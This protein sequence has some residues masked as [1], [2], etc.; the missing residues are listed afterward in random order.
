MSRK[1]KKELEKYGLRNVKNSNSK[2]GKLIQI[3][4]IEKSRMKL[5]K[6]REKRDWRYKKR[7]RLQNSWLK[8][9]RK[10]NKK[11]AKEA[12]RSKKTNDEQ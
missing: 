9:D 7:G 11:N 4:K 10:K 8:S 1:R 3:S 5:E 2:K 6:G 12:L